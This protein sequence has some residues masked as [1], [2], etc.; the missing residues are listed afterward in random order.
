M[1]DVI[2]TI[3]VFCML[4][5]LAW[6]WW[7]AS[8]TVLDMSGKLTKQERIH[9]YLLLFR[10]TAAATLIGALVLLAQHLATG[11]P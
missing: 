2:D 5:Y 11:K 1:W 3:G 7:M 10:S 6:M 4:G 9:A 8:R